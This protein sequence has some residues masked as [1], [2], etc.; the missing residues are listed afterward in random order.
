MKTNT[1][2]N[3]QYRERIQS[4][5]SALMEKSLETIKKDGDTSSFYNNST[6]LK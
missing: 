2:L 3:K 6:H 5:M 4:Q 1:F